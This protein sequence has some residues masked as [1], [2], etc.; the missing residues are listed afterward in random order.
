MFGRRIV[1]HL[2]LNR[3]TEAEFR[4][5][6][7]EHE[8]FSGEKGTTQKFRVFAK[9]RHKVEIRKIKIYVRLKALFKL[10]RMTKKLSKTDNPF[11]SYGMEPML[12]SF[13]R[14]PYT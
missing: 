12:N 4:F 10:Y 5:E 9:F 13:I 3:T 11:W 6:L 2:K 1:Q 14:D 7:F 8:I